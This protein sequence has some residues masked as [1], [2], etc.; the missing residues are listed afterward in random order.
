[1]RRLFWIGVGVAAAYYGSK[2]LRSQRQKL[3]PENVAARAA[4]R[5]GGVMELVRVSVEEGRRAAAEKEAEIRTSLGD[6][7]PASPP[8]RRSS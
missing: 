2:W 1:M 8:A 5:L 3:T 4:E 7:R 6:R